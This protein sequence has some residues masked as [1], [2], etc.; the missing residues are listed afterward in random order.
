MNTRYGGTK[1]E[2]AR[3]IADASKMT[4]VQKELGI[5]VDGSSMSFGGFS[6]KG[7]S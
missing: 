6:Y 2:M 4:E 1:E 3:L 7:Y 5:T